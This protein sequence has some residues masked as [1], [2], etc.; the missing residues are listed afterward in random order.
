ML[1]TKVSTRVKKSYREAL[2]DAL[3]IEDF[4][5]VVKVLVKEAKKGRGWAVREI[6]TLSLPG[7]RGSDYDLDYDSFDDSPLP[8][9]RKEIS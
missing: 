9:P 3:S 6:L 1:K 5:A 7:R 8:L 4:T 2:I